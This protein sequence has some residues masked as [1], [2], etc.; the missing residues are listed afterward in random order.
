M[1]VISQFTIAAPMMGVHQEINKARE[2]QGNLQAS[3]SPY[4]PQP[5]NEEMNVQLH[6]HIAVPVAQ[7]AC[8]TFIKFAVLAQPAAVT[9]C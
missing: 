7:P 5:S 6:Q 4:P 3:C 2:H 8:K 1:D 9:G